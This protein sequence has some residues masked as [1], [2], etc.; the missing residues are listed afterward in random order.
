MDEQM[1]GFSPSGSLFAPTALT[2]WIF[3]R[4]W[5][6]VSLPWPGSSGVWPS[7]TYYCLILPP[8][9][10]R[11]PKLA[12]GPWA[13]ATEHPLRNPQGHVFLTLSLFCLPSCS[14]LSRFKWSPVPPPYQGSHLTC[15]LV[16]P[17]TL[18]RTV[19]SWEPHLLPPGLGLPS[20]KM[21]G[22]QTMESHWGTKLDLL[23]PI[24]TAPISTSPRLG[25]FYFFFYHYIEM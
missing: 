23:W 12:Q 15:L 20:H 6:Q 11:S 16:Q 13:Q 3:R 8:S 19:S 2:S 1:N 9:L 25:S 4:H 21:R 22:D 7:V 17:Q 5:L 14:G 18:S 24:R 10:H